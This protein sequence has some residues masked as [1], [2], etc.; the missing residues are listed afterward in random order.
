MRILAGEARG[1][2]LHA[3]SGRS[4][5]PTDSR[6]RETLFNILGERVIDARILDLYA[7]S[8]SVGLEALSRGAKFCVFVEQNAAATQAI[9]AN[10]RMCGWDDK[11][12]PKAQVWQ[13]N[14]KGALQKLDKQRDKFDIIFADPPFNDAHVLDELTQRMDTFRRLL[15]NVEEFS[16]NGDIIYCSGILVVQHR[17]RDILNM[18][19]LFELQK[20]RRTGESS[21]D[22]FEP[23]PSHSNVDFAV[24]SN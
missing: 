3:P 8:G 20:S 2:V 18:S 22:F 6:S 9:R 19:P 12:H 16:K 5:R 24:T 7:G 14:V 1:R 23:V 21:L 13:S 10:L 17:H 15:H 4:T 11:A